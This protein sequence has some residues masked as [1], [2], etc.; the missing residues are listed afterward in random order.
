MLVLRRKVGESLVLGGAIRISVL[1]IEG[2]RVKIGIMAPTGIE[3]VRDEL[4]P[5]KE[6][7]DTQ[8]RQFAPE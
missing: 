8:E 4:L 5:E 6:G 1:A 7:Q 3:I 2:A